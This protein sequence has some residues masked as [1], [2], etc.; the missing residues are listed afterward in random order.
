VQHLLNLEPHEVSL[1]DKGA[2][3]RRFLVLKS[4]G[5]AVNYNE[6]RAKI[7]KA[8]PDALKRVDKVLKEFR[9]KKADDDGST[10][11]TP[12]ADRAQ[13]ALKAVVRILAPFREELDPLAIHEVLDAAGFQLTEDGKVTKKADDDKKDD[14]KK[15]PFEKAGDVSKEAHEEACKAA[16]DAY[17]SAVAKLGSRQSADAKAELTNKASDKDDKEKD[18]VEKSAIEKALGGA[19]AELKPVVE[20]I[21]KANAELVQKNDAL[22]KQVTELRDAERSREVV[23]KAA[24]FDKIGVKQEDLVAVLKGIGDN[25]ELVEKVHGLLSAANEQVKKAGEFKGGLYGEMGTSQVGFTMTGGDAWSKIEAGAMGM[26]QK[27]AT[28]ITKAAAIDA[29]LQTPEGRELY[30]QHQ[31]DQTRAAREA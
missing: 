8:D 11:G 4:D 17:K 30:N 13:T 10:E 9:V 28:P 16:E 26:V 22:L 23:A 21:F 29:F 31:R 1:V 6:L 24:S 15:F 7:A 27:S 19:P 14:K 18:D 12:L 2:N 3:L 25:K 20:L 5:G